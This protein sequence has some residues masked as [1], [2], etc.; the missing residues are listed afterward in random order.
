MNDRKEANYPVPD[1]NI[2]GLQKEHCHGHFKSVRN[3]IYAFAASE[4]DSIKRL[5]IEIYKREKERN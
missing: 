5:R 1:G 2:V 4:H 3:A